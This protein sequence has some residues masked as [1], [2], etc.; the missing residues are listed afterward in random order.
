MSLL[1]T[2]TDRM[3]FFM[4]KKVIVKSGTVFN[5]L[6]GQK[7]STAPNPRRLRLGTSQQSLIDL[8]CSISTIATARLPIGMDR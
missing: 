5:I 3:E 8:M 1:S 4:A 6:T 7:P 2:V